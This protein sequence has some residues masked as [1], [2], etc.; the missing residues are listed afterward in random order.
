MKPFEAPKKRYVERGIDL[1]WTI[2]CVGVLLLAG[3]ARARAQGSLTPPGAP[4]PVMKSLDQIEARTPIAAADLP[5]SITAPGSYYLTES[6]SFGAANTNAIF[7]DADGVTI[8]L[9]GCTLGGP[10]FAVG[11]SGTG[12]LG[13]ATAS[14]I[15]IS[16]GTLRNWRASGII[17]ANNCTVDRIRAENNGIHGIEATG[18]ANVTN[19]VASNN[20]SIGILLSSGTMSGCTADGNGLIGISLNEASAINCSAKSNGNST[21]SAAGISATDST[22]S[23]CTTTLNNGMGMIC[24][25]RVT[26]DHSQVSNNTF[27]G[28]TGGDDNTIKDCTV[29]DNSDDGIDLNSGN[30]IVGNAVNGHDSGTISSFPGFGIRVDGMF[31]QIQNNT[32]SRNTIGITVLGSENMVIQN[33]VFGTTLPI[34][35]DSFNHRGFV[36]TNP[37][38]TFSISNPWAN[39][40]IN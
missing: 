1:N 7:I 30:R 29:L 6:I 9:N 40:S 26:V 10:G 19:C 16:N 18:G 39:F 20:G 37:G 2:L 17:I 3:A 28:I 23:N 21:V 5:I 32:A 36:T 33:T 27:D 25:N 15:A 35:I 11:S 14:S 12:I 31:N 38:L 13:S 22:L 34:T 4:A 8:D 24:V